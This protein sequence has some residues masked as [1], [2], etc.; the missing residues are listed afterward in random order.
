MDRQPA[1]LDFAIIGHQENWQQ[2]TEFVNSVRRKGLER[3][4][5]T[6]LKNIFPYIPPRELFKIKINSASGQPFTGIYIETFID[7]DHLTTEYIRTNISKVKKAA[8]VAEKLKAKIATLGGFTSIVI[9]GNTELI[10]ENGT[11]FT[12]GNTLTA[13]FIVKGVEQAAD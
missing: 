8:K 1:G 12:T 7:P 4:S 13:A 11:S 5:D 10:A 9:E 3:L 2:V 6:K